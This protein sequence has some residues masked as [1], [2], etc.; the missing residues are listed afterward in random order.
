MIALWAK[1]YVTAA[2]LLTYGADVGFQVPERKRTKHNKC[3]FK[4][5]GMTLLHLAVGGVSSD[6][7]SAL[8]SEY[9]IK[10]FVFSNDST[11]AEK[12]PFDTLFG[13]VFS[14]KTPCDPLLEAVI[15]K[16][17]TPTERQ[18][19]LTEYMLRSG[20]PVN[21]RTKEGITPLLASVRQGRL[22][23]A[24]LLLK[25]NADPNIAAAG[26]CTPLIVAAQSGRRDLVEALLTSG[27]DPDAQLDA[28]APDE[29]RCVSFISSSYS[30]FDSCYAPLS[31]LAVAAEREHYGVVE[32]LLSHGADANL[33]IV[34]H[35]HGKKPLRH[36]R[37]RQKAFDSPISS[38]TE[39]ESEPEP[40]RW[41]GR[42]SVGTALTW[43]RGT[44]RDLLLRHGADPA[45]EEA[46][47]QCDCPTIAK[48]N[49]A[50]F[51]GGSDD[52]YPT[53]DETDASTDLPWHRRRSRIKEPIWHSRH[54]SHEHQ[55]LPRVKRRDKR[56]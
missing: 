7:W 18:E 47:R 41:E 28:L 34:H 26:G 11:G 56:K 33:P 23:L 51:I 5:V 22:G 29:C 21:A 24:N 30:T 16:H 2:I 19:A 12:V 15:S 3:S 39:S 1:A 49:K 36:M 40:V 35:V 38:V 50:D 4:F 32:A 48:R 31:A 17:Q 55:G 46:I 25:H 37:S 14:P 27:A 20:V 10:R 54:F 53:D 8:N 52:D 43:A 45:R 9:E 42:I 13:M 44:V 6:D